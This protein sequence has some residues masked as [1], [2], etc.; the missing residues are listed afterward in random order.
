MMQNTTLTTRN[1]LLIALLFSASIAA[2]AIGFVRG[3]YTDAWPLFLVWNLFLAWVPLGIATTLRLWKTPPTL[4]LLPLG[5]LWL[6]FFP[7]APYILTDLVHFRWSDQLIWLDL[8]MFL[9]F[10]L[11][12]LFVGYTSLAW[13][14]T[15][16]R[17]RFGEW[18]GWFFVLG[19]LLSSGFGVYIGRFLRFNSW[20]IIRQPEQIITV[21]LQQLF[22]PATFLHT[23][24]LSLTFVF[25]ISFCY[26]A[27]LLMTPLPHSSSA[28][29]NA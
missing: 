21:I 5:T 2:S 25:L 18:L 29:T 10:A 1:W 28:E 23:W 14:H 20:D 19:A 26:L 7:N 3:L 15:V 11:V 22:D 4:A 12:G 6:L 24:L 17:A 27:M 9:S 8:S 16:V 13:M